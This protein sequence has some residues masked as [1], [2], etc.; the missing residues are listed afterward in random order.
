MVQVR[1]PGGKS[2][3]LIF[4]EAERLGAKV[5]FCGNRC[6]QKTSVVWERCIVGN[7]VGDDFGNP[8]C[9]TQGKLLLTLTT[10][11]KLRNLYER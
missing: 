4:A 11:D 7:V 8:N 3:L 9:D 2:Q 1:F 6:E 5:I 10:C